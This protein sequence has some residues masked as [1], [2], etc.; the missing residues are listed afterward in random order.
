MFGWSVIKPVS[1]LTFRQWR[2]FFFLLDFNNDWTNNKFFSDE[3][4]EEQRRQPK[5]LRWSSPLK[6]NPFFCVIIWWAKI[7]R[8]P[9]VLPVFRPELMVIKCFCCLKASINWFWQSEGFNI[10]SLWSPLKIDGSMSN[11]L[12]LSNIF[13]D[14]SFYIIIISA[15]KLKLIYLFIN[16]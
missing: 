6:I 1:W 13:I 5:R 8:L 15:C 4:L 11:S 3:S 2:L 12:R 7:A 14:S 10:E 9:I 16:F